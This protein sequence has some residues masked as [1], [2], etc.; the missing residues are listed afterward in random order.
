MRRTS[1]IT[2]LTDVCTV[3]PVAAATRCRSSSV[4]RPA[5]NI[6]RSAKYCS[7]TKHLFSL[8]IKLNNLQH[9]SLPKLSFNI[10][11][12]KLSPTTKQGF[13]LRNDNL[14]SFNTKITPWKYICPESPN[15]C[16]PNHSTLRN[17]IFKCAK[18][19]ACAIVWEIHINTVNTDVL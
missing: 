5:Q 19:Y 3:P 15:T 9:D 6:S 18:H 10:L 4:T 14:E 1:S 8:S 13:N 16:Q 11:Q 17:L 2:L 12:Q 7:Q